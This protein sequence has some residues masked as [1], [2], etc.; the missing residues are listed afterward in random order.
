M[1]EVTMVQDKKTGVW[2]DPAAK[3]AELMQEDWFIAQ[4]RRMKD[5]AWEEGM[6]DAMRTIREEGM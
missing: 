5:E 6:N 2:Y 4:M 1:N 3:F